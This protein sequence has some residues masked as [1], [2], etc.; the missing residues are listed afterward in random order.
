VYCAPLRRPVIILPNNIEFIVNVLKLPLVT[1]SLW[2]HGPFNFIDER[3]GNKKRNFGI[4]HWED[5]FQLM[6]ECQFHALDGKEIISWYY[7]CHCN[8]TIKKIK[9]V[10]DLFVFQ[11]R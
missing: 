7:D 1:T 9:K 2:Y 3:N 5:E 11:V 4:K 8:A 6:L 10:C